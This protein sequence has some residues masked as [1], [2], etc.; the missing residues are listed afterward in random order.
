MNIGITV[1]KSRRSVRSYRETLI[2]EEIIRDSLDCAASA[3]TARNAQP[4]LIGIIREKE[5]LQKLGA[6][7]DNG[8]FISQAP[9]CFALF[10]RREE[11]YYLEDCSAATTQLILGLW[12]HG[13]GSCWVA[14]DKKGYAEEVRTLLGVPPDYTLVSLIP[15]GYPV[16]VPTV[17][18]KP[19]EEILFSE[20]FVSKNTKK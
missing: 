11:K 17:Q 6:L 7:A 12:A 3:P 19:R 5:T 1:I 13:V 4:W 8:K 2:P 18:K 9:L 10:G 16:D 14:E 15:A 20:R